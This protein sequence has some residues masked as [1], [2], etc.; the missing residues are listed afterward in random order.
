MSRSQQRGNVG[1]RSE[2]RAR[3]L[4]A[5]MCAPHL[6]H[7]TSRLPGVHLSMFVAGCS[8]AMEVITEAA[9]LLSTRRPRRRSLCCS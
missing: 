9:A 8:V 1:D 5:H 2:L 3:R 4:R 6:E 7:R